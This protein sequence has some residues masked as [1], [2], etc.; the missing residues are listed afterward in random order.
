MKNGDVIQHKID[1]FFGY[2]PE[3]YGY[4]GFA[5]SVMLSNTFGFDIKM[6]NS[7]G[8]TNVNYLWRMDSYLVFSPIIRINY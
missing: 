3:S 8:L 1:L 2:N 7:F 4:Y 5:I 6:S